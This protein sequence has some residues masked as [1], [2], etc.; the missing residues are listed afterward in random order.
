MKTVRLLLCWKKL[1][2]RSTAMSA[3][4]LIWKPFRNCRYASLPCFVFPCADPFLKLE[5]TL[6]DVK[7]AIVAAKKLK[8][9]HDV[10]P[11]VCMHLG[12]F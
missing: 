11:S 6:D 3:L 9:K 5:L 7:W 12:L 4:S 8:V 2:L 10:C 1:G